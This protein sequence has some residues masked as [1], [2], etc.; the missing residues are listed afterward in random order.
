VLICSTFF[1]D[2]NDALFFLHLSS[3]AYVDFSNAD[4]VKAAVALSEGHLDGRRLLIKD[5]NNFDG[6]PSGNIVVEPGQGLTKTAKR[7]AQKQKHEPG[8]TLFMGNLGFETDVNTLSM[9]LFVFPQFFTNANPPQVDTIKKMFDAHFRATEIWKRKPKKDD[10]ETG[11]G[12]QSDSDDE[13]E[14]E[15]EAKPKDAGIRKVRLGTFEDSNK[16]KGY[17]FQ[18]H[19]GFPRLS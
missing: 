16:C 2:S 11:D 6:R 5:A 18:F 19:T 15:T 7:I 14:A 4:E 17:Y 3:F 8:P 9:S 10:G 12:A 13:A 1:P